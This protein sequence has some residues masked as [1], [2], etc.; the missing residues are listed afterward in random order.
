MK[1]KVL[2]KKNYQQFEA[3][4]PRPIPLQIQSWTWIP[5]L[6]RERLKIFKETKAM[7]SNLS[8]REKER[9]KSEIVSKKRW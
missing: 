5:P 4:A 1:Q 6:P 9:G 7:A 3:C 2:K 8:E